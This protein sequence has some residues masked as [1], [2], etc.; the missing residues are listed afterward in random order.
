MLLVCESTLVFGVV[1]TSN[2]RQ[3]HG[4]V[5]QKMATPR[6]GRGGCVNFVVGTGRLDA[7]CSFNNTTAGDRLWNTYTISP[8]FAQKKKQR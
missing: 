7:G 4:V 6:H 2:L 8:V 1:G 5:G 3:M